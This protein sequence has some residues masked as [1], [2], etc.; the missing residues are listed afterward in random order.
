MWTLLPPQSAPSHELDASQRGAREPVS[1]VTCVLGGPGTGKTVTLVESVVRRVQEGAS[2]SEIAVLAG[3]RQAA[4]QLRRTVIGRIGQAQTQPLFTTVHG[5]ALGLLRLAEP[6]DQLPWALLRAPEQEE[7]IRD[8]LVHGR[9]EWP[10][11]LQPA[12]E[13]RGFARQLREVLARIRQRSLDEHD[14]ARLAQQRQSSTLAAIADFLDEYLNVGD[15]AQTLD[16]A[17][18]VYR[19]R[20]VLHDPASSGMVRERIREVFV[21]DAHD[22]D[23]AQTALLGDLAMLG[24]PVTVFGDPDQ[25]VSEFRGATSQGMLSLTKLEPSRIMKLVHDHRHA[26][27]V[28]SS[29]NVL[30]G[31]IAAA[32]ARTPLVPVRSDE[33]EVT[34]ELCSSESAEVAHVADGIRRT[35]VSGASWSDIA[36][37][38]RAGKAQ[39]MPLTRALLRLGIPVEVA[40]DELVLAEDEAVAALLSAL[41][42]AASSDEPTDDQARALA[43]SPLVGLDAIALRRLERHE[44]G[45]GV[46]AKMLGTDSEG[47]WATARIV[48]DTLTRVSSWLEVGRSVADTLWEVWSCT[49]WPSALQQAA[50][51]GDRHANHHLD[52]VVELFER[53]SHEP[54]LS[55]AAGVWKFARDLEGQEIP[56]DT[57]RESR[58]TGTGVL[59]TTAHRAK[60]RE[61]QHVW[62]V[63]VQEGR[64]PQAAPGGQLLD[65]GRLLDGEPRTIAEHLQEERRLFYLACA[66]AC[67]SLH[68]SAVASSDLQPSRFLSEL[69]VPLTEVTGSPARPLTSQA[70][71]GELRQALAD[72]ERSTVLRRGAAARLQRLAAEGIASA[73]P[74]NW[75]QAPQRSP[76]AGCTALRLSGSALENILTCPRQYYLARRARAKRPANHAASFGSLIHEVA[77]NGQTDD[78][79]SAG[80]RALLDERWS[81]VDFVAPWQEISERAQAED[82]IDR[83]AAWFPEQSATLLGVE[84]GFEARVEVQGREVV[85]HG[86]VDRLELL[87]TEEGPKLRILDFKTTRSKPTANAVATNVQLGLYQLAAQTGAFDALAPGVR[88]VA[89]AALVMLRFDASGMPLVMEQSSLT[90][91]PQLPDEPLTVGPTWMHDRLA[92]AKAVLDTGEF[93]ATPGDACRMCE[94]RSDC[95]AIQEMA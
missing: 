64:W 68:V 70:L 38:A 17:E 93:P 5:L 74:A 91:A 75:W 37:I 12:L 21:D 32:T 11:S 53:A 2:L 10:K 49:R 90:A 76:L 7:R 80:M 27:A 92:S 85:L 19:T 54:V 14:V 79:D 34:V 24:I 33:G 62:V 87:H 29:L 6:S 77:Q 60:G 66:R 81:T 20:V 69:G 45:D 25:V 1:G 13:T 56:A 8:L 72:P 57:G 88:A 67:T 47:E 83:L 46:W 23:P 59:V 22:L 51:Q 4:Q 82:M 65:P 26:V 73:N 84:Q 52:A 78:L 48:A 86:F 41:C 9:A 50:L 44:D 31:R 42:L 58:I 30:R 36:V 39:L 43:L 71:V 35:V 28:A 94:F 95:P 18:L 63:G 3:S 16:Y 15:L 61:W 55:G 40:A 89:S